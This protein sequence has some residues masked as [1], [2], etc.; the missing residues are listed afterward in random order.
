V[1]LHSHPCPKYTC[2]RALPKD[3]SQYAPIRA[4]CILAL[5]AEADLHG[6]CDEAA[7]RL[8]ER[9]EAREDVNHP[10]PVGVH[11]IHDTGIWNKI[12]FRT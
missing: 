6:V 4:R 5:I 12:E 1:H 10:G 7:S 2:T 3:T 8:A 11:V 9:F